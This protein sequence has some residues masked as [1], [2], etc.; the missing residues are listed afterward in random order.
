MEKKQEWKEAIMAAVA[1]GDYQTAMRYMARNF[2]DKG[3]IQ[4]MIENFCENA[5]PV[6]NWRE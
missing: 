6:D 2:G 4:G 5:D 3:D 1:R